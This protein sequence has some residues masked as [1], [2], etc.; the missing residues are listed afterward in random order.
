MI[1]EPISYANNEIIDSQIES[2]GVSG[3]LTESEKYV[4]NTFPDMNVTDIFNTSIDGTME[5]DGIWGWI[6]ELYAPLFAGFFHGLPERR[7]RSHPSGQ[8]KLVHLVLF[9]CMHGICHQHVCHRL[10]KG[11]RHI[12]LAV[13]FS[14][15]PTA[16]DIIQNR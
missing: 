8:R 3:F 14:L 6:V 1:L 2:T 4:S 13:R 11:S 9:H 7:I 10:L 15:H 16:V 12:C 5:I